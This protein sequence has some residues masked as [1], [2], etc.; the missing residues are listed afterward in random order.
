MLAKLGQAFNLLRKE[1]NALRGDVQRVEKVR[2][3]VKHGKDGVSPDP[4]EIVSAVLGK[5]A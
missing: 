1:V 4:D 3:V 5:I 2:Q